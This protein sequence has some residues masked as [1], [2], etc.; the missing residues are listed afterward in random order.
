MVGYYLEFC[1]LNVL[2]ITSR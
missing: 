2:N 1:E